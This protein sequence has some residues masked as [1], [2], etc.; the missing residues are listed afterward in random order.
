MNYSKS[1]DELGS[2]LVDLRCK[3]MLLRHIDQEYNGDDVKYLL[4]GV[5]LSSQDIVKDIDICFRIVEDLS[6]CDLPGQ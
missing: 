1:L 4:T 6:Q 5:S 2:L 3:V